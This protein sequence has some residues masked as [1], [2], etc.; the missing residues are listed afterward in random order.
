MSINEQIAD[1]CEAL[2]LKNVRKL[3][4]RFEVNKPAVA[5]VE[6]YLFNA[7]EGGELQK[8]IKQYELVEKT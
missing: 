3:T 1:V 5:E 8:V 6:M 4:L 7:D 2:G